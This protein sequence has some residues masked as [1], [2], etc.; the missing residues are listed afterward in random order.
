MFITSTVQFILQKSRH[1]C[2][3]TWSAFYSLQIKPA[4][5][6][7]I[8]VVIP[9][10]ETDLGILPGCIEGLRKNVAH[11]IKN[12]YLLSPESKAIRDF[13]ATAGVIVVNETSVLGYAPAAIDHTITRGAFT[14]LNRSG[15]I[16][17]Q[18]LKL[19]GKAGTCR[20]F[21]AID[22]DHILL[23]PHVFLDRRERT[24]FYQSG[25]YNMPYYKSIR[26]LLKFYP[27]TMFSYVAHKMLFDKEELHKLHREI[28]Q[29]SGTGLAW[30]QV[31]ISNLD[32]D[33][34]SGFSEFELYGNFVP[35]SKKIRAPWRD[36][37]LTKKELAGVELLRKNYPGY[38][39][40]TFP[41]YLDKNEQ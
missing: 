8:D 38:L 23:K 1:L 35:G 32:S 33:D 12:I 39:S 5:D 3:L 6:I 24:V 22:S 30:D 15:W 19:S 28:E 40:V 36:K 20:Y 27:V 11:P 17:Q 4:K 9:V 37:M 34:V 41:A 26:R 31:I 16:F 2:Y 10:I 14:G 25:E 21:L 18:L 7:E 29:K 13:A